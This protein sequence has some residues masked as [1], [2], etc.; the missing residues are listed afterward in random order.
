MEFERQ[1]L[2][3]FRRSHRPKFDTVRSGGVTDLNL[4]QFGS[5]RGASKGTGS[6][7]PGV[8]P[9]VNWGGYPC[10]TVDNGPTCKTAAPP[11]WGAGGRQHQF[12]SMASF[13]NPPLPPHPPLVTSPC[14]NFHSYVASCL[15][16]FG[17]AVTLPATQP[18]KSYSRFPYP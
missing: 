12:F 3:R 4:T 5:P 10:P 15:P 6:G 18:S 9:G 13:S 17:P 16:P 8:Q 7:L 2:R 1:A 11:L 14:L